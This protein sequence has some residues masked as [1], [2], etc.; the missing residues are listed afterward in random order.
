MIQGPQHPANERFPRT[1]GDRPAT[2]RYDTST[3]HL[4]SGKTTK[5]QI[6]NDGISYFKVLESSSSEKSISGCASIRKFTTQ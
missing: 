2:V 1:R 6:L 3:E 4:F 5:G